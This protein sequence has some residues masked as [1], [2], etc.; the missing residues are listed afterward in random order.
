[1]T[2]HKQIKGSVRGSA[3]LMVLW[4]SAALAAIAFSVATSVRSETGRVAGSADGLRAWYLA[5]GSVERAIQWMLWGPDYAPK[6][7]QPNTSRLIFSYASGDVVVEM[8]PESAKLNINMASEDDLVRL[9]AAVS[10]N[11][12]Q[13]QEIAAGIMALRSGQSVSPSLG[14]S[15]F[16]HPRASFQE[17]EE[18]LLVPGMT[19]ELFY[20][21]YI[22]DS[23]GR[24]YVSGGLRDCLSVWGSMGPFD[25]NT[26]SPA[27]MQ[28]VG[29][30]PQEA[31]MIVAR[32][33]V[34]PF[35]IGELSQMGFP[36]PRMIVGGGHVIWTL[37]A[38]ARLRR[39]D[40]TPSEVVRTAAATVKIL[41]PRDY[42]M[43]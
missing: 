28:A 35:G 9:V 18:L 23:E 19:P 40:G 16:Q 42:P 1:M 21:N 22:S 43:M 14:G 7:W 36:T 12:S 26:M 13:A 5:S 2:P 6:Y 17:I 30:P 10:G 24:L 8:I 39:P 41:N 32:R 15:T 11:P 34:A 29:V 38:T 25:A 3:L 31:Q 33:Q 20:G 27:L 4:A 37:R